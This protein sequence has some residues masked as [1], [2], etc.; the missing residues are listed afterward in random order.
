MRGLNLGNSVRNAQVLNHC[1]LLHLIKN[2]EQRD[3]RTL[4]TTLSS[5]VAK[6]LE[7]ES[8]CLFEETFD[9]CAFPFGDIPATS[10]TN[11]LG[12]VYFNQF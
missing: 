1:I 2:Y 9:L 6:F 4:L 11:E 5:T 12:A 7:R 8:Q 3:T 10:L